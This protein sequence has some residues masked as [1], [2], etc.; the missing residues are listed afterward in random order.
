MLNAQLCEE[1][2]FSNNTAW[3]LDYSWDAV[4]AHA[5]FHSRTYLDYM[6]IRHKSQQ[7]IH[8]SMELAYVQIIPFMGMPLSL[9]GNYLYISESI[10]TMDMMQTVFANT[11][12][13]SRNGPILTFVSDY[14]HLNLQHMKAIKRALY[15]PPKVGWKL[16][17]L[18][19]I[20]CW[21]WEPPA[22]PPYCA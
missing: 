10:S 4:H 7:Y 21:F 12:S 13:G 6:Y 5:Q 14:V 16:T 22:K 15:V 19:G 11:K 17:K 2:L 1:I 9:C 3:H 8:C 20:P 18:L